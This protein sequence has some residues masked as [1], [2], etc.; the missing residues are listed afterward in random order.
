MAFAVE[1]IWK[2]QTVV[3]IAGGESVTAKDI[4]Q[5]AIARLEGR[6]RVLAVNDAV[7]LTAGIADWIHAAD[8]RWWGWHHHRLTDFGGTKTTVHSRTSLEWVTGCLQKT[9]KDGFDPNPSCVRGNNSGMQAICIAVH[10]G[11]NRLILVGFDLQGGHWFGR[12]PDGIDDARSTAML[13]YF[14]SLARPLQERGID[15]VNTSESSLLTCFP[16]QKL[17]EAL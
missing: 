10:A 9:G 14:N 13:P 1:P 4:R 2:D 11:A 7:Y 8:A 12:H 6:C 3:I 16:K 5:I 17:C 15:V